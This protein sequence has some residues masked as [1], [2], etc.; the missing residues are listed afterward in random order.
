M[1]CDL[2]FDNSNL[3]NLHTLT[4]AAEDVALDE[5]KKFA[6]DVNVVENSDPNAANGE[7]RM[8]NGENLVSLE[9][10][11]A[12]PMCHIQFANKRDLI[13]HAAEHGK[14]KSRINPN[15]PHKCSKCWKAFGTQERLQRHLLCHGEE[16][17]KPLQCNVCYKRFMNNSALACHMKTHSDHKYYECPLCRLGFDQVNMLKA[18]I[19]LHA[20]D[21]LFTC[22]ACSKKFD[23]Y[24][25]IRKHMRTFHPDK[26]YPCPDCD[27]IFPRPDKLKLHMLRHSA[28]REFMC[29]NCGRQ[30][31]RKDKL[32]EHIKRMHSVEREAKNQERDKPSIK[33]FVP[34]V[35][36]NDYH[37]FIYKCHTCLLGF[38]RRGMLVN[39][40][41]KRHPDLKP[42]CIPELN[43]PILKTQ[44]DYY[45]QY[46]DKVYKSSSKRKAHIIKNHPGAELPMSS[47]KRNLI[48]E[49][50]GLPNP[51]YSQT[52]GSITTMPHSCTYCHK[53]YASKAKLMQHQR[54]KHPDSVPA[55]TEKRKSLVKEELY[56]LEAA[57]APVLQDRYEEVPT[58]HAVHA[59]SIQTTD[60]LT[61][62]M[63]ELTQSLQ[64]YRP[65]ATE[66]RLASH[67][68]AHAG[69]G[70]AMVQIQ[71]SQLQHSTI[72]LSH[73]GQALAHTQFNPQQTHIVQVNGTTVIAAAAPGSAAGGQQPMTVSV[74]TSSPSQGIPGSL[75]LPLSLTATPVPL[76]TTPVTTGVQVAN[77]QT[78]VPKTWSNATYQ[79]FR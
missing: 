9:T 12:C 43:L 54:K 8:E 38:K 1:H 7:N 31:K 14:T 66:Y 27:K 18:H 75:T 5:I 30:F 11:L 67:L 47:R 46:C 36:P 13:E 77:G 19:T 49:I 16:D 71:P 10:Y 35:S 33:K 62:A 63:S 29:E 15:R 34:K 69:G 58:V 26:K 65:G 6:V 55:A 48:P 4:H 73:L 37:R 41:A 72:E 22:P 57:Q 64:E 68:T 21:G 28:H 59:D 42:E 50:P 44:R 23:D 56:L 24:T 52:V 2:T 39:H 53:Q 60:L 40:L 45:C 79:T 78:Y 20:S 3:L 61:Q 70:P 32:K 51:T 74:V 17:S 25:L 76:P